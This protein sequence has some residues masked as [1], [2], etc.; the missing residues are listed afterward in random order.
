M[1]PDAVNNPGEHRWRALGRRCRRHLVLLRIV[2]VVTAVVL[3]V[4]QLA[5]AP[6]QWLLQGTDSTLVLVVACGLYALVL[7]IPFVPSVELGLLIM[8]LFGPPGAAGAYLA[9]SVG[10]AGAYL[11]G[12]RLGRSAPLRRIA[13]PARYRAR[14]NAA[15]AG[16]PAGVLPILS[17][18]TLLNMPGNTAVGGG[19]GIAMAYGAGRLLSPAVFIATVAVATSF[20]PLAFVTGLLG[21]ER[22]MSP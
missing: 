17:L 18:M 20:L 19:G 9:T 21:L 5:G 3:V 1:R 13:L 10:L 2:L 15:C 8:A 14:L 12:R 7:A 22:W 4:I 16:L 11:L 6:P